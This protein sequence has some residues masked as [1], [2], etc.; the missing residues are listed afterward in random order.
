[1]SD[2]PGDTGRS[3]VRNTL[4]DTSPSVLSDR[5]RSAKCSPSLR[6][7]RIA[8]PHCSPKGRLRLIQFLQEIDLDKALHS[9]SDECALEDL[10][11]I[12]YETLRT[13]F[14]E[15]LSVS[16]VDLLWNSLQSYQNEPHSPQS[17]ITAPRNRRVRS[18]NYLP[19]RYFDSFHLSL[20]LT[21]NSCV[22]VSVVLFYSSQSRAATRTV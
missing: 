20:L 16:E 15:S 19:F 4:S 7:R 11:P 18:P 13:I 5:S 17:P 3:Q 9:L 12:P 2:S 1:M 10:L 21:I 14:A 22:C 8:A 6:R